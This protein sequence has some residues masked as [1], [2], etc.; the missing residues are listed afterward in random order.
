MWG[1]VTAQVEWPV[2]T[3]QTDGALPD[4]P[5]CSPAPPHPGS[6]L[7]LSP[8]PGPTLAVPNSTGP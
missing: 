4:P 1:K 8:Q 6:E 3:E 7:G 5:L 2:M